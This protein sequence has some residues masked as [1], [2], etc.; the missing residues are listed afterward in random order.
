MSS[1]YP[2]LMLWP[3][4]LCVWC[5]VCKFIGVATAAGCTVLCGLVV[6]VVLF[7]NSIVC[8][9]TFLSVFFMRHGT[10]ILPLFLWWLCCGVCCLCVPAAC[11]WMPFLWVCLCGWLC[12]Y[13]LFWL[14]WF[15]LVGC[16]MIVFFAS[17]CWLLGFGS[18]IFLMLLG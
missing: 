17:F 18:V 16:T 11:A 8:Q 10:L 15:F 6:V 9:C 13:E 5:G 14:W 7:E 4:G 3:G 2:L 12:K 1:Q